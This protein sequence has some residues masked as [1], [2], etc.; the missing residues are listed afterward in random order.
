MQ[1]AC[2]ILRASES[3]RSTFTLPV[4]SAAAEARLAQSDPMSLTRRRREERPGG[5]RYGR[6]LLPGQRLAKQSE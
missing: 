2:R 6:R 4:V 1:E 5:L 3:D